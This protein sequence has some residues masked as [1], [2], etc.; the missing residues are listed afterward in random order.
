MKCPKCGISNAEGATVC[1]CGY[2]FPGSVESGGARMSAPASLPFYARPVGWLVMAGSL[3]AAYAG[4]T[5]LL[6]GAPPACDAPEVIELAKHALEGSAPFKVLDEKVEGIDMPGEAR[7]DRDAKKRVCRGMLKMSVRD[8]TSADLGSQA[9]YWTVE[10]QNKDK[11]LIW[12][13]IMGN[14]DTGK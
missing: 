10:W 5:V 14:T 9:L 13:Q 8:K 6:G 11:G 2:A 7:Y 12:L 3:G 1:E 4:Y